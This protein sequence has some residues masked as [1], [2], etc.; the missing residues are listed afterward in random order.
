MVRKF[1]LTFIL[2]FLL[3]VSA[4]SLSQDEKNNIQ[5]FKRASPSIV[6]V[7]TSEVREDFFS[8][9]VY[10]RPRGAGTGFIWDRRGIIVTNFHVINGA[11][12]VYV[13]LANQKRYSARVIGR[14]PDKDL[15]VLKIDNFSSNL[16]SLPLGN[17]NDLQVGRKVLAI[18]NPFGLDTTLTTGVISALGREIASENGRKIRGLIQTDAAINPGNSGGP[19]LDSKGR[20]IGVNTAIYSPTGGNVGIGFA[21]PISTVKKI[22]PQLIQNGKVIRPAI[23]IAAMPDY[24]LKRFNLTG[25]GIMN[26]DPRM[27]A[28]RAGLK[29]AKRNQFGDIVLGDVITEVNGVKLKSIDDL[30]H[31]LEGYQIG[32]SVTLTIIRNNRIKKVKM[33][34]SKYDS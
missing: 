13:T 21:I 16:A 22:I 14:D 20:V 32:K 24:W 12:K 10:E 28:G 3:S 7:T 17:S 25:V 1:Y 18:G 33:K 31:E 15:A 34:L 6:F 27:P 2:V 8:L 23:G 4:F 30:L 19:L 11:S 9:N 5:I 26:V 29:G